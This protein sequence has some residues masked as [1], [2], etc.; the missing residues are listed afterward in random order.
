MTAPTEVALVRRTP[1]VLRP[2]PSRVVTL[3]SLPGQE[4]VASGQS[5][6]DAVIQRVLAL[7]D[8][9]VETSLAATMLAFGQRHHDLPAVLDARFGLVAHR[10]ADPNALAR[11]RRLLIG[12]YFSKEYAVE[13]AALFN[14]SMVPHP[15]QTGLPP[16][17]TRFVMTVRAVGEGHISSVE[18]RTGTIGAEDVVAFDELGPVTA[19]PE[20][21]P[22]TYR[23]GVFERQHAELGGDESSARFVLAGLPPTFA[24]ADLELALRRLR[25]QRLTRGSGAR[26]PERLDR[27][28]A[29]NYSVTFPADSA[30]HDRVLLPVSPAESN[31]LED[32]RFVRFTEDDGRVDYRGIYTA[33]DGVHVVP[34]LMRTDDFRTF[35]VSQLSGPAAKNKGMALFPR[36]IGGEYVALSRWDR[37]SNSVA[38]SRD[39]AHWDRA[40]TLQV[41]RRPWEIVQVG[42][43][44]PP[45][46]TSAGWLVLTHGVGPMR[47]Y[48]IGAVLLDLEDPTTVLGQLPNPLLVP[49]ADEREGYVPNVVYSCGALV[50]G[51]TLVLPYGCSDSSIRVALVEVAALL[52]LLERTPDDGSAALG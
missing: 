16:G 34:Q 24:R 10:L 33:F 39:L 14:P 40:S 5:R 37:E 25:S 12:A 13:A 51:G 31:G 15:D 4:L 41:P 29:C 26:T 3:L 6:S 38:R 20:Q 42:N 28:A 46:E 45:I 8:A 23:R 43:C 19:S 47:E 18:F 44:G 2:D 49:A 17:S 9:E 35:H 48:S 36:P 32:V 27:I 1:H 22:T 11:P 30:I 52:R 7:T 21:T 50:H